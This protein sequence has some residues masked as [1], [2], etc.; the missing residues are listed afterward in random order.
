MW[1][2]SLGPST[3]NSTSPC[4]TKTCTRPLWSSLLASAPASI[5]IWATLYAFCQWSWRYATWSISAVIWNGIKLQR[6]GFGFDNEILYRKKDEEVRVDRVCG[7]SVLLNTLET[8][9]ISGVTPAL[10]VMLMSMSSTPSRRRS[11]SSTRATFGSLELYWW[12]MAVCVCVCVCVWYVCVCVCARARA[13]VCNIYVYTGAIK[14][15]IE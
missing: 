5:S 13:C 1:S 14:A 15:G 4:S 12:H 7:D 9:I 3:A 6:L 8:A 10:L 11:A 2:L